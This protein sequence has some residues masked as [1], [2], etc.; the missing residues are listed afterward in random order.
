LG[1]IA[2]A[3]LLGLVYMKLV[4]KSVLFLLAYTKNFK[5]IIWKI[6]LI[7]SYNL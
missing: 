6:L 5:Y 4:G 1:I 7:G 3:E 2:L